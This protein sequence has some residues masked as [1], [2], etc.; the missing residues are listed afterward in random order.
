MIRSSIFS[1]GQS[2]AQANAVLPKGHIEPG[3]EAEKSSSRREVKEETGI[4]GRVVAPLSLVEFEAK[5]TVVQAMYFLMKC[6]SYGASAE[7][8]EI[9]WAAQEEALMLLTHEQNRELLRAAEEKRRLLDQNRTRRAR[10]RQFRRA[11]QRPD[12]ARCGRS[13]A[14]AEQLLPVPGHR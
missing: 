9:R 10:V 11:G 7:A 6:I 5:R 12:L 4:T 2:A 8:R 1:L 13:A 14:R 3:E